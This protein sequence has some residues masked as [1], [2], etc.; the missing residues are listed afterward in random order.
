MGAAAY[1]AIAEMKE[2]STFTASTQRYV[3]R[4]LDVA[5]RRTDCLRVWARH[6]AEADH[7]RK[8]ADRY[9]QL[10]AIRD[11]VP[12]VPDLGAAE[13]MFTPLIT[14]SA[15]DLSA[16]RLPTFQSYRFLYERLVGVAVRP[17]L[18]STFLAAAALPIVPPDLRR[19]LLV[20]ISESAATAA[21]WSTKDVS[22]FPSWVDKVETMTA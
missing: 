22:F 1:R 20:S 2:F 6:D 5:A 7:I 15:F 10:D 18:P 19:R 16:G 17:W 14:L 12:D 21:G 8:Q 13:A 9:L 4:S 11:L 3:R